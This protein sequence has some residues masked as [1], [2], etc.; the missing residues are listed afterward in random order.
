MIASVEYN[1]YTFDN[2]NATIETPMVGFGLPDIQA[3]EENIAEQDTAIATAYRYRGR[4]FGWN[5]TLFAPLAS[6]TAAMYLAERDAILGA[7]NMQNQ[8][9]EGLT[10]TFTLITGDVRTLR[11]VRPYGQPKFDYEAGEPGIIW[12]SYQAI[13]R[14]T[15]GFFEGDE[16][17]V[18]QQITS[19]S[20]YGVVVPAP[21]ASPLSPSVSVSS[22][23][24]ILEA[25]NNGNAN[26]TTMFT[27]IGPGTNFTIQNST[28]GR[29]MTINTTLTAGETI[30]ID[31]RARRVYKNG[32]QNI[33]H[34]TTGSWIVMR[35]GT[36]Y[37]SFTADS[38]T[39]ADTQL[40][41]VFS[42]TYI[43]I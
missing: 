28:T 31:T 36:N 25:V 33:K 10:M 41:T 21:V 26:A 24:D 35:P 43:N 19:A 15:Y 13:F 20:I 9:L 7:M 11:E 12:N 23:T 38:G 34:L 27:I 30:S 4:T 2:N 1:G 16:S 6:P 8:P 37:I 39:T 17:D 22:G 18:T 40:Q 3:E 32:T 5:G 29:S 14:S 42:D